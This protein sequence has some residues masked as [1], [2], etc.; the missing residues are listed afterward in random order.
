MERLFSRNKFVF[1]SQPG[2]NK[3]FAHAALNF[4]SEALQLRLPCPPHTGSESSP[5]TAADVTR[6]KKRT[7]PQTQMILNDYADYDLGGC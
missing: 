3:D 2:N 1:V 4:T 6:T 7:C 5:K